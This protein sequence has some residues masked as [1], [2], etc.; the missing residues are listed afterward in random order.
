MRLRLTE[1]GLLTLV[2]VGLS[3]P[4][5]IDWRGETLERLQQ[6]HREV[7]TSGQRYFSTPCVAMGMRLLRLVGISAAQ[8]ET[9]LGPANACFDR[10]VDGHKL[11][12]KLQTCAVPAWVF[13]DLPRG[14]VGGGPNLECR[15]TNGKTCWIVRWTYTA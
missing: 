2:V 9:T 8:L 10:D 13:Y 3:I 6:C 14:S 15:T 5:V 12:P 11:Y 7:P 4:L 1:A